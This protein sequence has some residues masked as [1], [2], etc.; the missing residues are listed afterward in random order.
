MM[1]SSEKINTVSRRFQVFPSK[2][3]VIK[4]QDWPLCYL[5]LSLSLSLSLFLPA[6]LPQ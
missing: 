1:L 5:S 2:G 6:M 3:V 4:E